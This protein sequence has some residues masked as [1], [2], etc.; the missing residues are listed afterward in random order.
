[1]NVKYWIEIAWRVII[2]K[3]RILSKYE[4]KARP[5]CVALVIGVKLGFP[6]REQR[7]KLHFLWI[8]ANQVSHFCIP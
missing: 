2:Y 8:F 4:A 3:L 5:V 1:M 6:S 7:E